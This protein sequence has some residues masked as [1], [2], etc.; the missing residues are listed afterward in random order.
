MSGARTHAG[1]THGYL[2]RYWTR[3]VQADRAGAQ[4]A[5]QLFLANGDLGG[6]HLA[7]GLG[8]GTC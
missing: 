5:P 7:L 8:L 2:H 6:I 1:V 3:E 4:F